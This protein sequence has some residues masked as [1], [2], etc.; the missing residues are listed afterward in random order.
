MERNCSTMGPVG[1][2]VLPLKVLHPGLLSFSGSQVLPGTC[3]SMGF[4]WD[5]GPFQAFTCSS[6]ESSAG[7]RGISVLR[8]IFKDIPSPFFN[9]HGFYKVVSLTHSLLSLA[10][11]FQC[12]VFPSLNRPSQRHCHSHWQP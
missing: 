8:G 6:M 2:Q 7:W 5:H 1:S 9:D 10:P 11:A 12:F 3:L 4:P